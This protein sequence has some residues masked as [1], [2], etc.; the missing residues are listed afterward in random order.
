MLQVKEKYQGKGSTVTVFVGDNSFNVE[1]DNPQPGQ[2]EL[3]P[4]EFTREVRKE[5]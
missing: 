2:L 5:K 3:L 4:K 1:L